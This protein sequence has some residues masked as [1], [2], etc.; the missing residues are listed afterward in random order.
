MHGLISGITYHKSTFYKL[1]R[2]TEVTQ[3]H[4]KKDNRIRKKLQ[5]LFTPQVGYLWHPN[6]GAPYNPV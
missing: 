5:V 3:N 2:I 1:F 4:K 6:K